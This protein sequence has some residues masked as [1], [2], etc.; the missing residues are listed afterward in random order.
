[1]FGGAFD[2]PHL[3]H[4]ALARAAVDQLQLDRLHIVP[5][6]QAWHKPLVLSP[7]ANRLAMCKLAFGDLPRALIDEREL[8][9]PGPTCTIDTLTELRAQYPQAELFLLIGDDQAAALHT[10]QRVH[11]ILAIATISIAA[12]AS[13]TS[14]SGHLDPKNPLSGLPPGAARVRL[15]QLP[16]LPHSATEVRRLTAAG[17]PIGHLLAPSVAGYIATHHL[18]QNATTS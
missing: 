5:T 11:E 1:M 8:H 14:A 18:Y 2:P 3:A 7:A 12:R 10:W 17:Q 9:R 15:L 16:A 13:Q 4:A 6:G